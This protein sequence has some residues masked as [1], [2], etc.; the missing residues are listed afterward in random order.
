[1]KVIYCYIY[2]D[3]I[4]AFVK[5]LGQCICNDMILQI[6]TLM[7]QINNIV[8]QISYYWEFLF[9]IY[10][11]FKFLLNDHEKHLYNYVWIALVYF[12]WKS[13]YGNISMSYFRMKKLDNE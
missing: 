9:E 7:N 12:Y 1:M 6:L 11:H 13:Y 3:A 4:D 5:Y 10:T 2:F 8:F